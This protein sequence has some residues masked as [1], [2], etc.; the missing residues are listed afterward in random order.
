MTLKNGRVVYE[1]VPR[2]DELSGL[3]QEELAEFSS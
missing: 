3:R 1:A 2:T